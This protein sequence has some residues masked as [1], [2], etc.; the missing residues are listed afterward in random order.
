MSVGLGEKA[1]LLIPVFF[2]VRRSHVAVVLN[3]NATTTSGNCD[4]YFH[5]IASIYING[6]VVLTSTSVF[7][8]TTPVSMLLAPSDLVN[9]IGKRFTGGIA[10]VAV[11]VSWEC[12][13][14][15]FFLPGSDRQPKACRVA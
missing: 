5:G 13:L 10:E 14:G 7:A 2:P 6:A 9:G 11:Y 8:S 1:A 4:D 3:Q 12:F 15:M